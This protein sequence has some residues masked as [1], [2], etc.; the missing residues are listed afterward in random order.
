MTDRSAWHV[1]DYLVAPGSPSRP[2]AAAA[3][4][5]DAAAAQRCW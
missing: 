5:D 4:A 3:A 2:A 1:V